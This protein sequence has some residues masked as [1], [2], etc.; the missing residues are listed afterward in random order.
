MSV[1]VQKRPYQYCFSGNA[2]FYELMSSLAATDNTVQIELRVQFKTV[3]GTYSATDAIPF[4]PV[5]G[6]VKADIADILESLLTYDVPDLSA[7]IALQSAPGHTGTFYL[8]FREV[9][10]TNQNTTWDD[11]EAG[12]AC[13][14][15]KGGLSR[16]K[17]QGNNFW[18]NYF[19]VKKPFLTWQQSGRKAALDERMYLLFLNLIEADSI[20][21]VAKVYF[22]D[23]TNAST[24]STATVL[25][26]QCVYVPAGAEQWNLQSL[27]AKVIWYW[28][29]TVWAGSIQLTE[30]FRFEKDNR[31]DYNE[32]T[33]H[34]RGSLGGLDSVR[35]RGDIQQDLSYQ[36]QKLQL[37]QGPDYY[38][39][40]AYTPQQRIAASTELQTWSGDIGHLEKE[41]QDRLRDAFLQRETWWAVES[42]WW[43]VNILTTK[44]TLRKS[45]SKLFS[46]PIEWTLAH[47]GDAYYTPQHMDVGT[48]VF[49]SNVCQAFISNITVVLS[50]S[51]VPGM[52]TATISFDENDPQDASTQ[53]RYRYYSD[54]A[55]FPWVTQAYAPIVILVQDNKVT[56]LEVQGICS[57]NIFGK[58][59]TIPIDTRTPA[60]PDVPE[61]PGDPGTT[62]VARTIENRTNYSGN[63]TV[64]INGAFV[65]SGTL[66]ANSSSTFN[67][68][69]LDADTLRIDLSGYQPTSAVMTT[70]TAKIGTITSL[71]IIWNNITSLDY[72][73][74]LS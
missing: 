17:Y 42:K 22:I 16:F 27:A 19:N 40:N 33:L 2:V 24:D 61:D 60:P 38:T 6:M 45:S 18:V 11:S 31:N 35:V 41:E 13:L 1:T 52:K 20:R 12:F 25:S 49:E 39:G 74:I 23:G 37:T 72:R 51:D 66:V 67:A 65:A 36:F 47:E 70:P 14:A 53:I 10:A 69:A 68:P 73:I 55:Q 64:F 44:A 50:S 30:T 3:G 8:Q 26:G 43:P 57:N 34:Y 58:L 29:I 63:F 7:G 9:S 5:E 4:A 48:A 21:A 15:V 56:T 32:T 62:L 28:E 46:F 54:T 71:G 59:V